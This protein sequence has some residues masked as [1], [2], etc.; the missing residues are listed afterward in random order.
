MDSFKQ[1]FLINVTLINIGV[2]AALTVSSQVIYQKSDKRCETI[3]QI[4]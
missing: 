1:D 3:K 4:N 2:M